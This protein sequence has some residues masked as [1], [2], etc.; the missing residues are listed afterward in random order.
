M[1]SFYHTGRVDFAD[2]VTMGFF[3]GIFVGIG[4]GNF[5]KDILQFGA[6]FPF[7]VFRNT[8]AMF[9]KIGNLHYIRVIGGI[10]CTFQSALIQP[11][12]I[13]NDFTAWNDGILDGHRVPFII[14]ADKRGEAGTPTSIVPTDSLLRAAKYLVN[15]E[16]KG[17][18][19]NEYSRP[20]IISETPE[21][22]AML[23]VVRKL[24]D[25]RYN[26]FESKHEAGTMALWTR[27]FEKVCK[28]AMLHGISSNVYNPLITEKSV[29]WAWQFIDHLTRR[30]LY[31]AN[32]HVYEN[33]FDEKCQGKAPERLT[34]NKVLYGF[35]EN[36]QEQRELFGIE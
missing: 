13:R 10:Q 15:L 18:L 33:Q 20:L 27:A 4:D 26:F 14:E 34:L 11:S 3:Y 19:T 36:W 2:G 24:C 8:A 23:N 12:L 25:E 30:M 6:N 1:K 17:N 7:C 29:K 22:T 31:M 32:L 28:L 21:A 9:S 35:P 16:L 5:G